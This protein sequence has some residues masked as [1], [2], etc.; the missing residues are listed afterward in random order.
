MEFSRDEPNCEKQLSVCSIF[1]EFFNQINYNRSGSTS[2]YERPL[3]CSFEIRCSTNGRHSLSF[4]RRLD[5]WE[6]S[7]T[8][9][10][11]KD[12][13]KAWLLWTIAP[14]I[15]ESSVALFF[16]GYLQV[17]QKFFDW[18][19]FRQLLYDVIFFS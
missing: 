15:T 17:A 10:K 18:K 8:S 12:F 3:D 5:L 9:M 16:I 11:R 19:V 7:S 4:K 6:A 13:Q 14:S 2:L 1:I